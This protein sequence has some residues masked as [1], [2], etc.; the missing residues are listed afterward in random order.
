MA[1]SFQVKINRQG[2]RYIEGLRAAVRRLW[3]SMCEVDGLAPEKSAFAVFSDDNKFVPFYEKALRK[4]WEAEA[5]Y[6]A[7]GYV[8]LTTGR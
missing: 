2:E 7:G 4:L 5:Q 3:V 1:S 8:G 6:R